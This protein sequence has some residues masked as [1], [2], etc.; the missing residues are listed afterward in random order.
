M[1]FTYQEKGHKYFLDDK[2]VTG[3]TTIL[4]VINKPALLQWAANEAV[5]HIKKKS[6]RHAVTKEFL[7]TEEALEEAKK[8]YAVK[9][10]KSADIGTMAHKWLEKWIKGEN[11]TPDP[12]LTIMTDNFVK[13]ATDNKVE[14]LESEKRL[15]SASEWYA[16]CC[17]FICK[18]DGKVF[19]GDIKT[20]SGIYP[21]MFYQTAA[22]QKAICEMEPEW[23]FH[24][25]VIVNITKD[26]K[27]N[28]EYSYCYPENLGAF[29]G[30]LAIYRRQQLNAQ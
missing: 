17:D 22:Y 5:N 19:M 16:G 1:N 10:D 2:P 29:M 7:V 15:Y 27:L 24:G 28:V 13:W 20:S 8:A 4:G 30:A 26:G 25:N 6:P 3:V 23:K 14:F 12:D 21:E 18:I 9:R 11:P